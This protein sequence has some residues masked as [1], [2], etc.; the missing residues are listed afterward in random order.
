MEFSGNVNM[1]DGGETY[2]SVGDYSSKVW[3]ETSGK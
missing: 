1:S 3:I 2:G